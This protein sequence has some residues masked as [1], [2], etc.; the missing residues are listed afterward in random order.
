MGMTEDLA[1]E[2]AT[3]AIK[4]IEFTGDEE[5]ISVLSKTLGT[6]SQTA[7]EAFM[8]AIRVRRANSTARALLAR[9]MKMAQAELDKKMKAFDTDHKR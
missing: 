2:L 8:T 5:I 1:E 4:Y 9:K 3:E 7:E 6:S